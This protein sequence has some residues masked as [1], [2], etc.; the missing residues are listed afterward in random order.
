MAHVAGLVLVPTRSADPLITVAMS[1]VKP[2]VFVKAGLQVDLSM[3]VTV[4]PPAPAVF[5]PNGCSV[6][7]PIS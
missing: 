7:R 4:D 5:V 1:Y 3:V 6:H 2:A